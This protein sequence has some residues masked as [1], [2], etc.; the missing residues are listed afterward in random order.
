MFAPNSNQN[1]KHQY[2]TEQYLHES[3]SCRLIL[4]SSP[5]RSASV[6]GCAF[7][8]LIL[9]QNPR[10]SLWMTFSQIKEHEANR[11]ML[12]IRQARKSKRSA[13]AVQRRVSLVGSRGNWRITN[14]A[15]VSAAMS[16][17]A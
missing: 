5:L 8:A 16:K 13:R 2:K 10:L 14:L 4:P 3:T 6:F 7:E 11:R 9:S 17:W 15:A 12:A 1:D